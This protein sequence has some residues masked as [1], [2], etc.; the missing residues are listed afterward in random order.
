V[1]IREADVALSELAEETLDF[2]HPSSD[3]ADPL[4]NPARA[5]EL[6]DAFIA[7]KLRLP[8]CVK[9]EQAVLPSAILQ[10]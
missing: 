4:S 5:L 2:L 7:W 1:E 10:K 8:D 9:F 6:Y 3:E